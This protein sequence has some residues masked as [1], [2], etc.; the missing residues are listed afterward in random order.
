[1]TRRAFVT[2]GTGFIGRHLL[3]VLDEQGW[4]VTALHRSPARQPA[5]EADRLNPVMG[6]LTDPESVTAAMPEGLDA[7]FHVAADTSPWRGH[8]QRQAAVN[9]GG[10]EAVIA[11]ARATGA[12]R[13]VH[14][15]TVAVWGHHPGPVVESLPQKGRDHWVGYVRT[16]FEAEQRVKGAADLS[17]VI[18][19]PGHVLGRYDNGNW[20]RLFRMIQDGSLPGVPPGGGSFANGR[21]VAEALVAA[22]DKGAAGENYLLGG[23]HLSFAALAERI[24]GLLGKPAPK[25]LPAVALKALGQ[26]NQ[27]VS[28]ITGR[29]PDVTPESAYFVCHDE[30][31]DS[32]KAIATLGYREIPVETSLRECFEWQIKAGHLRPI[33]T[34]A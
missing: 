34:K 20:G 7:V 24:A 3:D 18:C 12:R 30:R 29:A 11:A 28:L 13:L 4:H 26:I 16:K 25:P 10:T 8:R 22:A 33:E 19:N 14:V 5:V 31:I 32:S 27:A 9:V 2:G 17:P 23:P 15:S 1:M 21:Q 6:D